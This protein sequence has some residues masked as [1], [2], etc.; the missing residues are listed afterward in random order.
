V[1][2]ILLMKSHVKGY[3]R[4][5]KWVKDYDN[6]VQKKSSWKGGHAPLHL[7]EHEDDLI[8][9]E[10]P[11]AA[12]I[13]PKPGEKGEQVPIYKLSK[14]TPVSEFADPEK[15]ATVLPGGQTPMTLNGVPFAP[16][17][18]AP[19]TL[20]GWA[21]VDGQNVYDEPDMPEVPDHVKIGAG[22][23]VEEP[24]GRVWVIHP[25]NGFGGYK[26]SFPKGTVEDGLPVQASA[27]KEA[28]EES[29]LKVELLSH[30]MDVKR[31]TSVAR[32][33]R[34]RRVGGTPSDA[35]WESQAVS[36]VPVSQLYS[37]LNMAP[38]HKL[39]EAL[40]AG[41]APKVKATPWAKNMS[42]F[43]F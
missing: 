15:I 39:A 42:G 25:T 20:H 34:A 38:D 19:T 36:L 41:P 5:G 13:H 3:F 10:K 26:G 35:G 30:F 2:K 40:G 12:A 22:V 23:I 18:D 6:K 4:D 27:I 33:Y 24:D 11:H 21:D 32:Y 31:T 1:T 17:A 16:W 7:E 37:A 8:T 29:G 14:A 28:Y 9:P 43:K